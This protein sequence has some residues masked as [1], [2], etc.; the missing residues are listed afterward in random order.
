VSRI[1]ASRA[2][3]DGPDV[4]EA[5]RP[6]V[7]EAAERDSARERLEGFRAA[8]GRAGA[9]LPP[10]YVRTGGAEEMRATARALDAIERSAGSGDREPAR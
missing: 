8:M 9:A 3:A 10:G 4:S 5:A 6:R 2:R 1:T 7:S